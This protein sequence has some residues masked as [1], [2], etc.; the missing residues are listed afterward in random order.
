MGS[1]CVTQSLWEL[2]RHQPKQSLLPC[3][4]FPFLQETLIKTGRVPKAS[5][6][7]GPLSWVTSGAPTQVFILPGIHAFLG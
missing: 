4:P 6:V 5:C 1:C 2:S 7:T 3:V